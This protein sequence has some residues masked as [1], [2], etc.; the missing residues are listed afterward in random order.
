MRRQ[1]DKRESE[2]FD[3]YLTGQTRGSEGDQKDSEV[4]DNDLTGQT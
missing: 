2:V 4:F 1:E 3:N